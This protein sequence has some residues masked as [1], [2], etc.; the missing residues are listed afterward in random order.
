MNTPMIMCFNSFSDVDYK[1]E[2]HNQLR[3][4]RA[5]IHVELEKEKHVLRQMQGKIAYC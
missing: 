5:K 3:H 1:R 2:L 4:E